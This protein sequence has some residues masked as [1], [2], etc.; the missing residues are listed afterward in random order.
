M[1]TIARAGASADDIE[2]AGG[3]RAY[4]ETLDQKAE[5][6]SATEDTS[7][8]PPRALKPLPHPAPG[9]RNPSPPA[10]MTGPSS[11]PRPD[12]APSASTVP[13]LRWITC[14]ALRDRLREA[15][16]R[17]DGVHITAEEVARL[18]ARS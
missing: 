5:P 3:I 11:L 7:F 8:T 2:A 12:A 1:L 14:A 10:P 16:A 18:A 6:G 4:R 9:L 13:T 17:G 15:A